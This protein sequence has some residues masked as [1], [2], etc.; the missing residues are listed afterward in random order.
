MVDSKGYTI[1]LLGLLIAGVFSPEGASAQAPKVQEPAGFEYAFIFGASSGPFGTDPGFYAGASLGVPIFKADPL[2]G[3]KLLGE[4]LVGW[5]ET[6]DR[7]RIVS[8]LGLV[9]DELNITV[10]QVVPGLKYKF[11]LGPVQPYAVA[12]IGFNVVLSKTQPGDTVGGIAPL[13]DPLRSRGVPSG[14]GDV[15]IGANLGLGV[16]FL[17]TENIFVGADFR[18]NLIPRKGASFETYGGKVGF[19]F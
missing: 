15:L 5:S 13:G 18:S 9:S 12:G 14:Q 10:F 17:L 7:L 6:R 16:D 11:D 19:R 3:Q 4:I 8:P 2:F 1:A